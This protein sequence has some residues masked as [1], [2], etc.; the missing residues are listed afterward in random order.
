MSS[1]YNLVLKSLDLKAFHKRYGRKKVRI[2]H[3]T[4]T[5]NLKVAC[6][7]RYLLARG[8]RAAD[9]NHYNWSH[10]QGTVISA[11]PLIV[12]VVYTSIRVQFATFT[13]VVEAVLF[14]NTLKAYFHFSASVRRVEV[15]N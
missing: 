3:T 7:R 14:A 5:S 10:P 13:D 8:S 15:N 9:M 6:L 11:N 12:Y 2:R 1:S 4:V